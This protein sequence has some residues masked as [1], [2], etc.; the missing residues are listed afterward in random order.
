MDKQDK[1][2]R[3]TINNVVYVREDNVVEKPV[4]GKRAVVVIDRGWI[5]AG[6]VTEKEGGRIV[7]TRALW[8]FGW[9]KIGFDG[10]L[11]NP[12]KA[13]IKKMK[14]PVDI[15]PGSEIYRV[16]VEDDWGM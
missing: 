2:D 7:L 11:D 3:I 9:E 1:I 5:Y 13:T 10:M 12:Q 14:Y 4:P 15:P 16:P 8:I 6:D